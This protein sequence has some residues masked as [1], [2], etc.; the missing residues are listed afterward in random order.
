MARAKAGSGFL[1]TRPRPPKRYALGC[2]ICGEDLSE[3][4]T[5]T[6]G[7]YERDHLMQLHD[8][9]F[10]GLDRGKRVAF[11]I[12]DRWNGRRREVLN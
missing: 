7:Q 6:I 9:T 5:D 2:G 11:V 4:E 3:R 12:V 8:T 1:L 10:T